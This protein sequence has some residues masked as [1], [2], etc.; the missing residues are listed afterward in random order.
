MYKEWVHSIITKH[1]TLG[2]VAIWK[3]RQGMTLFA[4]GDTHTSW[5]QWVLGQVEK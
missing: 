2:H 5:A 4:S 3:Q 1:P